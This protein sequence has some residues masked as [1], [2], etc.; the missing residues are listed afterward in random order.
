M[1]QKRK[2]LFRNTGFNLGE[3]NKHFLKYPCA[4]RDAEERV[5]KQMP[6]PHHP[7]L[8]GPSLRTHRKLRSPSYCGSM[9]DRRSSGP[10]RGGLREQPEW[11]SSVSLSPSYGVPGGE[12]NLSGRNTGFSVWSGTRKWRMG[13]QERTRLPQKKKH[14]C[15]HQRPSSAF[16]PSAWTC[17]QAPLSLNLLPALLWHMENRSNGVDHFFFFYKSVMR[18]Y[19]LFIKYRGL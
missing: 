6:T 10:Y 2:S 19:K 17:P 14:I 1:G 16:P 4:C 15:N 13:E 9:W 12:T 8:V 18:K 3:S 7:A 5:G 11:P